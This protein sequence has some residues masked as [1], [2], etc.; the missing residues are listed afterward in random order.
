MEVAGKVH[1]FGY[2]E[3]WWKFGGSC[4]YKEHGS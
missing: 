1:I 2:G 3:R 4:R